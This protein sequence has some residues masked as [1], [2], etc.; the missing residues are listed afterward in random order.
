MR[1]FN[2]FQVNNGMYGL[3]QAGILANVRIVEQLVDYIQLKYVSGLFISK[4]KST[5]FCLIV[6]QTDREHL[7]V[8]LQVFL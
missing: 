7:Y 6:L 5:D 8:C 4:E 2:L 1:K 3:K